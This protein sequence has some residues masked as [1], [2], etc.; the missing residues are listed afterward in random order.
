MSDMALR[1]SRER[2]LL[3]DVVHDT[4]HDPAQEML[5]DTVLARF[6][7]RVRA[8]RDAVAL[9][10]HDGPTAGRSLTWGA[11]DEAA[12][13]VAAALVADGVQPGDRVAVLAGNRLLWP[14]ADLGIL[15]AGATSV[16]LYPTSAPSQVATVLRDAGAAVAI[17]DTSAQLVKVTAAR[18]GLL[19]LRAVVCEDMDQSALGVDSW[20]AWLEHG[21]RA[22]ARPDVARELARRSA[23]ARPVD[24]A[25][26]IYTSGSTGEPKGARIPHA[27]LTASADAIASV[28]GLRHGDTT[29]SFLPYCHAGERVFGLYTRVSVGVTTLLVE[30][31]ARVWDAAR[32][33]APTVFGGLPRFWEKLYEGLLVAQS[34]AADDTRAQWEQAIA[35]GHE[36]SRLRRAGQPVPATLEQAWHDASAPVR[37]HL[38]RWLGDRLRV[39][40]TG[41]AALSREV[42]EHLDA[43]GVTVLG[44]Y[45]MTEHLC[46]AMHRADR[47]EFDSVGV[48]MPGTDIAIAADGEVLLRRG[49]LTFAGYHGRDDATVDAFTP[50]GAW[51]RT[52]DLGA[53]DARGALHITG[54]KKELI[55]LSTGKKVA[56]LPIEARLAADPWIAQAMLYGEGRKF[57]SALLCPRATTVHAWARAAGV[58]GTYAELLAHPE[59][60]S[61]VDAAVAKVNAE[62]SRTEQVRR[63]ALLE[64]ELSLE[65]DE[66]TPTLKVR[67]AHVA[68]R[69]RDRLEALYQEPL[70]P[71]EPQERGA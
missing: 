16:G 71:I 20:A 69:F 19:A 52:G 68:E 66:L 31:H 34:A 61:R 70:E 48:A 49:P 65:E 67:R 55:A 7:A 27:Y 35:L 44:A 46:V 25:L 13:A 43:C 62:L 17:V 39:A 57:V 51:L 2:P 37:A 11:W 40:T 9:V 18:A 1:A 28:L 60:R 29:L 30:D 47:Y 15:M 33:Y 41:G 36:R 64:R 38:A 50:D 45:G 14:V 63:Y 56:P 3:G 4:V 54:R 32:H 59:V 10:Q 5:H 21:R 42:A 26:L 53:L 12:H 24:D 22:L 8:D 23:A 6:A 58:V